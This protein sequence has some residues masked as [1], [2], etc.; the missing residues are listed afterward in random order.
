MLIKKKLGVI[1]DDE[2]ESDWNWEA[3][4]PH[5][6]VPRYLD[7]EIAFFPRIIGG[8]PAFLGEFPA[9]VSVQ[10]RGGHHTCGG[11]LIGKKIISN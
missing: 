7:D 8:E 4:I 5:Y 9:K 11:A 10:T 1:G 6:P 3:G 2:S